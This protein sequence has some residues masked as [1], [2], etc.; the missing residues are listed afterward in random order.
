MKRYLAFGG[1]C[2]YPCGGWD[3][4]KGDSDFLAE[5][6]EIAKKDDEK[7]GWWQVIDRDTMKEV[8]EVTLEA[9]P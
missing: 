2:Y 1:C 3:D 7:Y 6:F 8:E 4:F 5:A 9:F